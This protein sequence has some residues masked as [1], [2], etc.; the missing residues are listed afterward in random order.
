MAK[1]T[2]II[3][4]NSED[5]ATVI[6]LVILIAVFCGL[7][8]FVR[9]VIVP[10]IKGSLHEEN[11]RLEREITTTITTYIDATLVRRN[12]PL[13]TYEQ[14]QLKE[15]HRSIGPRTRDCSSI[16]VWGDGRLSQRV[17]LETIT[18]VLFSQVDSLLGV[19]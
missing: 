13:A 4:S 7:V 6:L 16:P 1:P 10:D 19:K 2:P 3:L 8:M 12:S 11:I 14:D 18:L 5:R 17:C 15:I 9:L